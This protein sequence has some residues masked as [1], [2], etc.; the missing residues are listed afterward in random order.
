MGQGVPG[1]RAGKVESEC[2]PDSVAI[3]KGRK[4][5]NREVEKVKEGIK[6]ERDRRG[7]FLILKNF[8]DLFDFAVKNL[9]T[10]S[11]RMDKR[12]MCFMVLGMALCFHA[13]AQT[14]VIRDLAGTVEIKAPG[15]A[16]WKAAVVGQ[17]LDRASLVS[18]GFRSTVLIMIGNSAV[19]VR[20]LTRLS[21]EEITAIQNEEQ[22]ILNLRAGRI[23]A[24]VKP[25][26]GGKTDFTVRASA[27]TAS[28]RGTVFDFDGTRL[29][30]EEGRVWLSGESVTGAYIGA[31]HSTAADPETGRT[32][33]AAEAVKEELAPA[34]PAG[35]DA[36]P[37]PAAA[38]PVSGS[39]GVGFD[40]TE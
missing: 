20:P 37:A 8:F 6:K 2:G 1:R 29:S 22:V 5:F 18:T 38:V 11:V 3:R 24:D 19:T 25:P 34:L 15:A 14:A 31:G 36:A 32:A 35:M 16:E 10:R 23:R 7:F 28:V 21:L 30:V 26:V 4:K 13:G 33:T 39:L 17:T 12:T 40:W 9:R 27:A